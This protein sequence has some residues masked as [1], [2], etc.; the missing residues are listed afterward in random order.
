[1]QL[2]QKCIAFFRSSNYSYAQTG[3]RKRGEEEAEERTKGQFNHKA[4]GGVCLQ[5][6]NFFG[7]PGRIKFVGLGN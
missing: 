3:D 1:M 2:F 5:M 7:G 4:G 6:D